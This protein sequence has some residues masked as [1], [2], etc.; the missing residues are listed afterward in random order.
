MNDRS[1]WTLYADGPRLP[2]HFIVGVHS[3][4]ESALEAAQ[5]LWKQG[6]RPTRIVGPQ[7]EIID[8]LEIDRYGQEHPDAA[9]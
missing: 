2:R 9:D 5:R 8:T 6:L 1:Y 3:S 4:R 7:G